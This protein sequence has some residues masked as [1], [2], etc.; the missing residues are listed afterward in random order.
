MG[1]CV[2]AHS[3]ATPHNTQKGQAGNPDLT[4]MF[5]GGPGW[6]RTIDLTVISRAL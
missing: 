6:I 2:Q 4:R 1:A 5:Y 3:Q